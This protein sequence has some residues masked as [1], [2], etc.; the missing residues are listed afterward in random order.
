MP[1]LLRFLWFLKTYEYAD[2]RTHA[3]EPVHRPEGS[4]EDSEPRTSRS[5]GCR[6]FCS[7]PASLALHG[8]QRGLR[9]VSRIPAGGRNPAHR[10][11]RLF[12]IRQAVREAIRRRDEHARSRAAGYQRFDELRLGRREEDGLCANSSSLPVLLRLSPA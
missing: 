8:F 1:C 3:A 4:D 11:E 9:L 10:L 6:R 7:R 2:R 5:Y 12:A